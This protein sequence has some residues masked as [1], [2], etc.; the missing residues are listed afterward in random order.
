MQSSQE[1]GGGVRGHVR[2]KEDQPCIQK[3]DLERDGGR[4]RKARRVH[5]GGGDAHTH[6]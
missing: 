4:P 6:K 1:G 2:V 5:P 3:K